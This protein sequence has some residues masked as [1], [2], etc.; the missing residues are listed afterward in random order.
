MNKD[1]HVCYFGEYV[2]LRFPIH[3]IGRSEKM[4]SRVRITFD[5][6]CLHEGILRNDLLK[7]GAYGLNIEAVRFVKSVLNFISAWSSLHR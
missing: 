2:Y 6:L 3:A 4:N 7:C 5:F 1:A